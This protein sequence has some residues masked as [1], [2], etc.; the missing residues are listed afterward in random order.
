MSAC[1]LNDRLSFCPL[2][3]QSHLICQTPNNFSL[4]I[5]SFQALSLCEKAVSDSHAQVEAIALIT[6]TLCQITCSTGDNQTA[7]RTQFTRAAARLLRK[8]DQCRA[9]CASTDL[10]WPIKLLT[11]Q[12]IKPSV[13]IPATDNNPEISTYAKLSEGNVMY[14]SSS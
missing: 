14:P 12:G 8:H 13:L 5:S 6:S 2:H 4:A 9:V 1:L 3:N 10:F 7:L 11:R